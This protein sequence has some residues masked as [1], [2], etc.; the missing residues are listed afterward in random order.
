MAHDVFIS[1]SHKDK[2]AADAVCSIMEKSGIRCW[3][4]PRDITPGAPFAEAIIDGIKESKVFVLIY[5]SNSNH[6]NQVI[7]E[8]DRAVHHGMAIIPLRLEDVPMSKQ[9]EYYVSDVHW[10]DALTPPLEIHIKK[11]G[12]VVQM[13]MTLDKV[14][15]G[16]I[17]DAF[18][19]DILNQAE[20]GKATRKFNLPAIGIAIVSLLFAFI[21]IGS[22]LFYKKQA[23]IR[24]ARGIA[25][26]QIERM[27]AE[28]DV[29]R[30]LVKPYQ[31]AVQAEAVL[32]KDTSL[33][34]LF[35]QCSRHIDVVTE[36]AGAK[37]F[38]KEYLHPDTV[39]TFLGI[40]PVRGVRVPIG[41]FRWKLEKE[42]YDTVLAAASTWNIGGDD[43]L[44]GYNLVRTMDK[45]DNGPA[46]MVRIP[47]TETEIGTLGDF[48][49][50][51]YEVTNREY[52][53][54]VDAGGYRNKEYWKYPLTE[55][56]R[57]FSREKETGEFVDKTG[58]TGPS[59]WTGSDYPEGQ[60][61]Y[62]VSVRL[63]WYTSGTQT[64]HSLR[65]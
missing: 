37:V 30:N 49:I 51:R 54:F 56:G 36:P 34:A 46:G 52:K 35:Y 47:A 28:N 18:R 22:V 14:D 9:L 13:L 63:A 43:M 62:P 44:S 64:Y 29:W 15:N 5:S 16:V 45:K 27:I 42:G 6:S 38:M 26:P 40:T 32:G 4:A 60:G 61:D 55:K 11:L 12:K 25:I 41:I 48:Y 8:V 3:M 58:R 65:N 20:T 50:G 7:K 23:K 21:L 59:T 57:S 2:Y 17:E 1:Y 33:A 39:W 10:L 24:W 31:L 53:E 19:T